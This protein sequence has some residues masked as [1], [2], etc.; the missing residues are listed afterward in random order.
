MITTIL[1]ASL[2]ALQEAP[3]AETEAQP[4]AETTSEVANEPTIEVV[5]DRPEK[6]EK[7]TDRNDPEYV[8]CKSEA[9]LGSRAKRTRTCMT[10]REWAIVAR[11]G[12]EATR[13]FVGA[14]QPGFQPGS[15]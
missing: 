6:K 8:R 1:I 13:D 2:F 3:P 5:E 15:N 4:S 12:N 10:N 14:N 9:V 7:I 11:Q